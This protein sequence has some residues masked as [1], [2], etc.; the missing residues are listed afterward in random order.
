MFPL[1]KRFLANHRKTEKKAR[2]L[3]LLDEID[4]T[5]FK[6]SSVELL[7]KVSSVE[8]IKSR[9]ASEELRE[10]IDPEEK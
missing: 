9:K 2:M 3:S 4:V 6:V 7:F 5:L 8:L 10:L 1:D